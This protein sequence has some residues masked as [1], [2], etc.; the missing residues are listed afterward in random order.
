M[1]S[2]F[3]FFCFPIFRFVLG[4]S[5]RFCLHRLLLAILFMGGYGSFRGRVV[6]RSGLSSAVE[7]GLLHRSTYHSR[8]YLSTGLL[9][10]AVGGSVRYNDTAMSR[11]ALRALYDVLSGRV[12]QYFGASSTG[13]EYVDYRE[14]REGSSSEVGRA[15]SVVLVFVG[16]TSYVYYPG[17]GSRGQHQ[18]FHGY[19]SEVGRRVA[20]R[21]YQIV[22]SS[23]RSYL[24]SYSRGGGILLRSL[25]CHRLRSNYGLQRSEEGSS[26]F[27]FVSVGVVGVR[28]VLGV[29]YVLWLYLYTGY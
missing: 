3:G 4:F 26:T 13:L 22:G 10:R 6:I 11:A 19:Y 23:V 17:V 24:G 9:L 2:G 27:C 29:G 8:D 1:G 7:G 20:S 18:V 14:V 21:L 28:C 5:L 16:R 25:L 12:L 15:S